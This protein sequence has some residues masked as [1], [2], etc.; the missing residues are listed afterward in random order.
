MKEAWYFYLRP[1][2]SLQGETQYQPC[3]SPIP[4]PH[5]ALGKTINVKQLRSSP[6]PHKWDS[7]LSYRDNGSPSPERKWNA[8]YP[9]G[10]INSQQ[11][12][13]REQRCLYGARLQGRTPLHS[14]TLQ[15]QAAVY[16]AV[17]DILRK[18]AAG[19][20]KDTHIT[21]VLFVRFKVWITGTGA[22]LGKLW[23]SSD[24]G[25]TLSELEPL[26]RINGVQRQSEATSPT[27]FVGSDILFDYHPLPPLLKIYSQAI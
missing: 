12:R 26:T 13:S 22:S 7:L 23:V 19:D 16:S 5:C 8:L 1:V 9:W 24:G 4:P 21:W 10:M 18:K 14:I 20:N 15:Q 11:A 27:V 2:A 25:E 17:H 6:G 3:W